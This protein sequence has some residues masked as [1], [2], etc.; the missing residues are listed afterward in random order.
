[1]RANYV[2]LC[3]EFHRPR[4]SAIAVNDWSVPGRGGHDIGLRTYRPQNGDANACHVLYFHGGG[5]VVGNLDS[6]DAICAELAALSGHT[7]TA[8]D[9]RLAPEHLFPAAL[10]DAEAVFR[11]VTQRTP[12]TKVVLAGD[13]AGGHLSAGLSLRARASAGAMPVGQL[14]IYPSVGVRASGGSY[15]RNGE[16]PLLTT[17]DCRWY[18]ETYTGQ[19]GWPD[20]PGDDLAPI[21]AKSFAGLP[22]TAVVTAGFD[23]LL[24][25]GLRYCERL[26]EAGVHFTWRHEPQLVHG[27]LRAR[28]MSKAA[29]A[30]FH[31]MAEQLEALARQ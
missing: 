31:W 6:H 7:L 22:A 17:A 2:A 15:E 27:F 24:D 10:D 1:M 19:S 14:L 3:R 13:S 16:A 28:H 9:Y 20:D 29:G 21:R 25:D 8:V 12:D 18:F 11:H 30:S 4:P 26:A 5:F 23:P